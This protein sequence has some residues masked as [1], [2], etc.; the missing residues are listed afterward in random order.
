MSRFLVFS[1]S[2]FILSSQINPPLPAPLKRGNNGG[3][4]DPFMPW[5]TDENRMNT[6]PLPVVAHLLNFCE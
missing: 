2:S 5:F 4:I 1:Y 3:I 6:L